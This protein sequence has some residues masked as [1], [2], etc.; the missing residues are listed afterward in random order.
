MKHILLDSDYYKLWAEYT[1]L[2]SISIKT[3]TVELKKFEKYLVHRGF[4][5]NLDFDKF[6][7]YKESNEYAPIDTEF[8]DDYLEYLRKDLNAN[9]HILYDNIVYLKNFF[10]FLKSIKKIE[11][12]PLSHYKNNNYERKLVDRSLSISDCRKLLK[13]ALKND[14]FFRQDYTLLLLLMTTGLRN[15]ELRKLSLD[16]I[17][18]ER[19]V[20]FVD[21]GQKKSANVVYMP[22]SLKNELNRYL[23][24]PTFK[25]WQENGNQL[26]FFK[27]SKM[28]SFNKLN[29]LIKSISQNAGINRNVTAH[30]F[31]HT[32]AYLMQKAGIDISIIQRQLRHASI[33]TTLRYL[34][35]LTK[36]N[37]LLDQ[38]GLTFEEN[39]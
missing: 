20:I 35:P 8:I 11:Y 22:T 2:K 12:N 17:S 13:V 33:A 18:F 37:E 26:V 25:E 31:R 16:Q 38:N 27:D 28:L 5:G 39:D 15:R 34:P 21:K 1:H 36:Y 32:T 3:Y 19:G 30:T 29:K 14:P 7:F 24:H 9:N 4:E 23:S 10:G 6:Y